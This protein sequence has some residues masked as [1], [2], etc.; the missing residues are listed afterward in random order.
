MFDSPP[1]TSPPPPPIHT[2]TNRH[3]NINNNNNIWL[4]KVKLFDFYPKVDD[5]VPRQKSTFGG[6]V[7]VVCLLITAYLLISEIYFFT[8][9]VREHSLKVDVTRGNRLPINIDI[10][11]PRLVCTDI[12]IDVV[13]GIDGKPIKDAAYQIVKERLD[14]KG[15]PFAKG[16]ALAGK[17]GIFSSRCTE[18]EFPKQKKGSSVF[19]RQKCC[20]SCDDLREYY[21]LNR[22]PQNFADDA[23]QCL[24]ER[25]IQDDEGC[26][27]YG[28]LQVQKMKGDFHIL[29]GLSAD[30]SHDGHAHHVHRITKENIGRVTQFNI[31]HHIHKFSFGDDI[32]GLINP[33]EGFGIVAQSLAV[34][35][36]YIQ[37]VPAI[38]KKNDYVLETNQYSYTYD[39][40]NVNVF[41][42][43]RIFPGI[44]FKYDMSPLMIE[45]DQTSKPIV[46]LITSICA[47][48]GGIFYISI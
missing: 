36:Y 8:F 34:Q 31:T 9:P 15:V 6:V 37:V 35:N 29:A 38:Y 27:I 10:H 4:E 21:R 22:I 13:D 44:Y 30:E 23:P 39:Y 47:I 48:G 3:R 14:S 32:D 33:L 2:T 40:R 1:Q 16:V 11:F 43:G 41:N 19:F 24:I 28:S 26:R 46:E 12:T 20:N 5:D 25:P 7:T 18:C 45:V 17:K 42:L